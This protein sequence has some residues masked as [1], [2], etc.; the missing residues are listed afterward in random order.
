MDKSNPV[1]EYIEERKEDDDD[2]VSF[3]KDELVAIGRVNDIDLFMNHEY[4]KEAI[5]KRP[6]VQRFLLNKY[7][8]LQILNIENVD[9][10]DV[11]YCLVGHGTIENWKE[12]FHQRVIPFIIEHDLPHF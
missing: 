4:I 12:L 6:K 9:S 11:R 10:I 2:L 5:N 7:W 1:Q 3:V 8:N